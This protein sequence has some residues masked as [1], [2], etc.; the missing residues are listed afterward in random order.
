MGGLDWAAPNHWSFLKT[1]REMSFWKWQRLGTCS[2]SPSCS[3]LQRNDVGRSPAFC[4][5]L[6]SHH[7]CPIPIK[8]KE[9]LELQVPRVVSALGWGLSPGCAKLSRA[10]AA[11]AAPR[12][13]QETLGRCKL[14][15]SPPSPAAGCPALPTYGSASPARSLASCP[16]KPLEN[17]RA[18]QSWCVPVLLYSQL[19]INT[20]RGLG[21]R[22][23]ELW[24]DSLAWS[25]MLRN[26]KV[27]VDL[28]VRKQRVWELYGRKTLVPVDLR[29]R[30]AEPRGCLDV[31]HQRLG[32]RNSV[33]LG[34]KIKKP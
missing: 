13:C 4:C 12:G 20:A 22:V 29:F 10:E 32:N 33:F 28:Q 15:F 8:K 31:S 25:D 34:K 7:L 24:R 21:E 9:G 27:F 18:K 19:S 17:K 26:K 14:S 16:S 11:P 5:L 6:C 30:C 3:I 23:A 2:E 1:H